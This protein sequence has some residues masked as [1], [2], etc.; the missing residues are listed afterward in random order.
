MPTKK[1]PAP[2]FKREP[3][4]NFRCSP[5]LRKQ[6][7]HCAKDCKT[8]SSNFVRLVLQAFM[9]VNKGENGS[10]AYKTRMQW[11]KDAAAIVPFKEQKVTEL[12]PRVAAGK[13]V[14]AKVA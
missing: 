2:K 4:F 3:L 5:E 10:N 7:D 11:V 1:K 6:I 14:K 8:G 9:T 13:T 12:P